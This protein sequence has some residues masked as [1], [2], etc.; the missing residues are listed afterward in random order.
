MAKNKRIKISS[1]DL[2][3]EEKEIY[4]QLPSSEENKKA[5]LAYNKAFKEALQS[6]AILRQKLQKVMNEQGI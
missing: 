3:G 1:T 4:L 5:Q 6:G 2:N